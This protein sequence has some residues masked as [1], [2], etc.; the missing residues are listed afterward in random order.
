MLLNNIQTRDLADII[1]AAYSH[2]E[3]VCMNQ[4]MEMRRIRASSYN[5]S[6]SCL[7]TPIEVEKSIFLYNFIN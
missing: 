3:R 1:Q 6:R 2:Y 5:L 4:H 7:K